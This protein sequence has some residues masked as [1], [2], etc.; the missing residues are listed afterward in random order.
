M[1]AAE[2]DPLAGDD[3]KPQHRVYLDAYWIDSTEVTNAGFGKCLAAG[4]CHPK[5]YETTAKTYVPY[6][7]HPDYQ[8]YPALVYEFEAAAD[9]CQ[10]AGR[11]LPT[12]TEWEKAARGTDAR[13]YPWGNTL[14]DCTLA[15]YYDCNV[16]TNPDSTSPRCGYSGY[17]R[18]FPVGDYLNGASPYGVLNMVGNVWEWVADWYQADYYANSP[19]NNPNGPTDGKYRVIRGG[20]AKSLSQ[21]LRITG[22]GSGAPRHN[23]D[24]QMGFRCAAG[25]YNP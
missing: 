8:D 20:G 13:L 2:N 9:Y 3:E 16:I 15:N 6:S 24:G 18:T 19:L 4:A 22:R 1:G 17:C 11:R 7:V 5:V 10:W 12:E 14:L 21:E 25:A 23:M